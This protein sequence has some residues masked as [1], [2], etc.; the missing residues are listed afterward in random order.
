[1]KFTVDTAFRFATDSPDYIQ[2]LGAAHDDTHCPGFVR[3]CID[4]YGSELLFMDLGCAGGG[5]VADMLD[6]EVQAIGIDGSQG[7]LQAQS[8]NRFPGHFLHADVSYPF[9]VRLGNQPAM[10]DV[11]SAWEVPEHI[12]PARVPQF[13][14][15]VK[16][17]LMPLGIFVGT[18]S[19]VPCDH[20]GY[21]Y[22]QSVHPA[23]WW[24][25]TFAEN[26]LRMQGTLPD[27]ARARWDG[28]GF[29]FVAQ[30]T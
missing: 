2:P 17:H 14:R 1:M 29:C 27:E 23:D 21:S 28:G 30:H 20:Q 25:R 18:I 6:A 15:N 3:Y 4:K 8:W 13:L 26:G 10:F 22:H 12:H 24:A 7:Q 11:I 5:I 19:T 9:Q 16:K